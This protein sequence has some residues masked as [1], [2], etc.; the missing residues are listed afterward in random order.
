MTEKGINIVTRRND[1]GRIYGITFI[2]HNSKTVWNGSRL[3]KEFSAN[4]FN[5][6]W[7]NHQKPELTE[8]TAEDSKFQQINSNDTH[9][10]YKPHELFEFLNHEPNL[11]E[12]IG[13]FLPDALGEDFEELVFEHQMKKKR[14]RNRS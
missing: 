1:T 5:D 12:G 2:D 9:S 10:D 6:W 4:V 7:N 14:K 3:G 13:G 11:I 8:R